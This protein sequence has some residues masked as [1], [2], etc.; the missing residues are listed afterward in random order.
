MPDWL[1]ISAHTPPHVW[2][3]VLAHPGSMCIGAWSTLAG[4]LFL[5]DAFLPE[6]S[7]SVLLQ[8]L[9]DAYRFWFA[10]ALAVGGSLVL[11]ALLRRW[12]RVDTSWRLERGG[13]SLVAGAWAAMSILTVI[14]SPV[15]ILSWGSFATMAATAVLRE[16]A[17]RRTEKTL[18]DIKAN[19]EAHL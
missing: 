4:L 6:I 8:P 12:E 16:Q 15:S 14:I 7:F 5:L 19:E 9:P 13:W 18:R 1:Y 17:V 10:G 2:D 11:L 3:R